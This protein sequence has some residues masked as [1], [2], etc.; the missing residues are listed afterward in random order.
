MIKK[1]LTLSVFALAAL[2]LSQAGNTSASAHTTADKTHTHAATNTDSYRYTAQPGDSYSQIARKAVQT[3]G[4][5]TGTKLSLAQI[6]FAENGLA[7]D[8]G[9]IELNL[10]QTVDVKKSA[11]GAWIEKAKKLSSVDKAAWATY[12]PL[13]DFNTNNIGEK[14]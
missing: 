4:L 2:S 10:G 7:T 3:Y 5:K 14:R 8:A 1:L 6:L 9:N 11:V 12:V 13:V